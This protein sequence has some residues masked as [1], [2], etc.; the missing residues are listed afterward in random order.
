MLEEMIHELDR[1]INKYD[2]SP[3]NSKA[4]ANKVV[5]LLKE[6]RTLVQQELDDV[7]TGRRIL[8]ERDFLGPQERE[9]RR[10]EKLRADTK[11]GTTA[12]DED[13]KDYSQYFFAMDQKLLEI[14]RLEM[15]KSFYKKKKE[16][17]DAANQLKTKQQV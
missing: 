14:R 3:W 5:S 6:H 15:R 7:S 10:L 8:T 2:A 1:L 4:T 13:A 16:V 11:A 17:E 9:R 12:V